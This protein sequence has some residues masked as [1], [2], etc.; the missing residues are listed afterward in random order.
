MKRSLKYSDNLGSGNNQN[1]FS[2][3]NDNDPQSMLIIPVKLPISPNSQRKS[4]P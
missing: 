3:G 1:M 4:K 2:T